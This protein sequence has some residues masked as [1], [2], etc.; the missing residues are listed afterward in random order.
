MTRLPNSWLEFHDQQLIRPRAVLHALPSQSR[1][2][3]FG[4]D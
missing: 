3:L 4:C 2:F 1:P